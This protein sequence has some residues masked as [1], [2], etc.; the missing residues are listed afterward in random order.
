MSAP[1]AHHRGHALLIMLAILVMG[2]VVSLVGQL[3][4]V[5]GRQQQLQRTDAALA[6]A[7]EAL[8]AYALT[9]RDDHDHADE[10]F[11]YL[12][13]PDSSGKGGVFA[14]GD[15]TAAGSCGSAGA[16]V[17]GLLPYVTLRLPDLRDAS[18]N[19][20]W[21]A[22]SGSFKNSPKAVTPMNWDAQAQ[23]AVRDADGTVLAVPDDAQGGAAA[24]IFAPGL[25]LGAQARG[26]IDQR[27][28]ADPAQATAYLE[29]VAPD[30]V[31]GDR[32]DAAGNVTHN[33]RLTWL[34]P[35]DIF[36][37]LVARADF[38][39]PLAGM[40]PGQLNRLI[41]A[42]RKALDGRLWASLAAFTAAAA[43][44]PAA[45]AQP[46]NEADYEQFAAKRVGDLPEL[47]P[48]QY[49]G[50]VFDGDHA[51]W[52]DQFRYVVCDDIKPAL[53]CL[54]LGAQNCRGALFFAGQSASGGPRPSS[55]KPT[56][57][58]PSRSVW[59]AH[60]FEAGAALD[61]L[62]G[63][64]TAFTGPGEYADAARS[65][66]VGVCLSPGAY[67]TSAQHL[68]ATVPIVSSPAEPA[69][70]ID[71]AAAA[72][73][74]GNRSA[75]LAG[76]GCLWFPLALPFSSSLRAY[77][78]MRIADLGEGYVFAIVDGANNAAA[79]HHGTLCGG[80]TGAHLGYAAAGIARPKF[81]LEF[82][83]R[84]QQTNDCSG[85]NRND[86]RPD[87]MAFVYWGE[88]DVATD[89][90]CH[91]AGTAGSG[92][93]PQNPRTLGTAAGIK[94]VQASDPHLPYDGSF[95]L[96]S[97]IHVR[98]EV[99]KHFDDRRVRA[100]QW[101]PAS[102]TVSIA[103]VAAHGLIGGQRVTLAGINP[104]AYDGTVGIAVDDATH[105]SYALATDPGTYVAGGRIAAPTDGIVG[106]AVWDGGRVTVTTAAAHGL[107]NGQPVSLAGATPAGYNGTYPASIDSATGF[108]FALASDPGVYAGGGR[109]TPA[110]MLSLR[111]YVASQL[112]VTSGSYVST[113]TAA[114][115]RD[116]AVN[117]SDLCTQTPTLVHGDVAID[118]D[119]V[120][121][122]ALANVHAGFTSA[123]SS[124]AA[125]VQSV[126]I[127]NFLLKSQ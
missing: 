99:D 1:P 6:Q 68:A 93:Q 13:C 115:L 62:R 12:P 63:P 46:R 44:T 53:G 42:Q 15:G 113:C 112:P 79:L 52:Q 125:G 54:T 55:V 116:L 43:G 90:N 51:N 123:Q 9:Y 28:R 31:R 34:T 58:P 88:A 36:S 10:M 108:S 105:F 114:Q 100:A 75:T 107:V 92:A 60:Y 23:L 61:L 29:S 65:A 126:A 127:Y 87:H 106:T 121:G 32:R 111:A 30:F 39:N 50:K 72:L 117:L 102:G 17:V 104:P 7:K 33:D 24:V 22:V 59:L 101:V 26:V 103:T 98:L 83:T 76:S 85:G 81:G 57:P 69:A 11:G 86:P 18:G 97:D 91:G 95:P 64:A 70:A 25:A 118:V 96:D 8:L 119:A 49:A 35:R 19:C 5:Y 3:D 80:A 74:L 21:Y 84:A 14:P 110:L 89:D 37:R 45:N 4:G 66:D 48:L 122:Q 73:V 56:A 124:G 2:S 40:P 41:D 38:R 78:K 82:D 20:L 77:F 27:C 16:S 94:T 109:L 120:S 47:A 67:L 71:L